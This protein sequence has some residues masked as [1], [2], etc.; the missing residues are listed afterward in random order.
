M[1]FAVVY[2]RKMI[3]ISSNF[4]S[5]GDGLKMSKRIQEIL[6]KHRLSIH[7]IE[8]G[9]QTKTPKQTAETIGC[10]L[11]QVVKTHIF[12]GKHTGKP[13]CII[14]SEKSSVD[15]HKVSL[16]VQEEIEIPSPEYVLQHTS[17]SIDTLPPIGYT[18]SSKPFIDEDLMQ[19]QEIWAIAGSASCIFCLPP[20]DLQKITQGQIVS[21]RN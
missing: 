18:L 17:F 19:Y 1:T 10:D 9:D 6:Q 20:Q 4:S 14:A 13:I 3:Y 2:N 8:F 11:G 16:Y 12:K 15:E 7:L 5:E 21:L